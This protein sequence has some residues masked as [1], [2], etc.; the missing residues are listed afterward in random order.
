MW[1][2]TELVIAARKNTELSTYFL[3]VY[4][5]DHLPV[6][7]NIT[8]IRFGFIVNSDTA[9]LPG[10]HWIAIALFPDEGRG[11][12]FDSFGQNPPNRIRAWMEKNCPRGWMYNE[13]FI[14]GPFTTLCGAYCLFYLYN[15]LVMRYSL[16]YIVTRLLLPQTNPDAYVSNFV[17]R[18]FM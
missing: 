15:R 16:T 2:T 17:N 14:Q 8:R 11:E 4:P 1:T 3:G 18:I 9:N 5:I 10:K 7:Q 6:L 12:V 13:H